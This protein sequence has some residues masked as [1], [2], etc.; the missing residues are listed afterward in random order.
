MNPAI[1]VL[2]NVLKGLNNEAEIVALHFRQGTLTE[3]ELKLKMLALSWVRERT[4]K[5]QDGLK[6]SPQIFEV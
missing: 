1:E 4:E 5:I 6:T 2:D 3:K